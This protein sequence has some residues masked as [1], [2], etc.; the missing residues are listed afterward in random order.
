MSPDRNPVTLV[1]TTTL[2]PAAL[3]SARPS[4]QGKFLG[5]GSTKLYVR[6]VTYGA[7]QPDAAGREYTNLATLD[8]DFA[9]MAAAG[10]N[11]VRI[12]HTTPPRALLDVA[13]RHG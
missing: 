10:M 7:F 6:G 8:R 5:V 13:L 12:P 4:V 2:A 9:Q 1:S 11:A 3:A